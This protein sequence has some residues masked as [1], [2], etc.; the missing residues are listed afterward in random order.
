MA[1]LL[2]KDVNKIYPDGHGA[3]RGFSL[4]I[5]DGEFV[6]LVGDEGSGKS[7]VLRMTAGTEDITSGSLYI[8]GKAADKM[9]ARER[10]AA[11]VNLSGAPYP[12]LTVYENLA[13]GLT[14]E[15]LEQDIIDERVRKTAHILGLTDFLDKFPRA[16]NSAQ[17]RSITAGRA[18]VRE[19]KVFLFDEPLAGL[20]GELKATVRSEIR[21]IQRTVGATVIYATRSL[22]DAELIADKIVVMKGGVISRVI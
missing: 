4:E 8:D 21:E 5:G 16:L 7:A 22:A 18:L 1:K 15:G 14:L 13:F 17:C 9:P 19:A 12:H 11:F 10:G 20:D 3:V 6:C 2:Y